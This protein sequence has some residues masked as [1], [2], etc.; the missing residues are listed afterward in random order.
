MPSTFDGGELAAL[1]QD[2]LQRLALEQLHRDEELSV[3]LIGVED[4]H[5][6]G[7]IE[8]RSRLRL[9]QEELQGPR[10][11]AAQALGQ[12]LER[13]DALEPRVARP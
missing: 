3:L 9:A 11:M 6:V 1:V 2:R 5:D 12:A 8:T 4:R 13:H 7:M 10:M